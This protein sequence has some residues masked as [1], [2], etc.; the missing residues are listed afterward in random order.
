MTRKPSSADKSDQDSQI[1]T[2]GSSSPGKKTD[3]GPSDAEKTENSLND[4]DGQIDIDES[5]TDVDRGVEQREYLK[6]ILVSHPIWQD[7]NFWEQV[8]WQCAIEQ[9]VPLYLD[10]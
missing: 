9:V 1:N 10:V 7:G 6:E 2:G 4:I 8:L 5:E 3:A